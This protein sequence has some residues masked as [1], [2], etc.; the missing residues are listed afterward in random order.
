[1]AS[2]SLPIEP[3]QQQ[4]LNPSHAKFSIADLMATNNDPRGA[5]RT[6][7]TTTADQSSDARSPP[8][9]SSS[10][11]AATASKPPIAPA[12]DGVDSTSPTTNLKQP[13][14][15]R[16]LRRKT[17]HSV[18]ERRRREKINERLIR[19]QEMVPAC[20]DEVMEMLDKKPLKRNGAG[21]SGKANLLTDEGER[22]AEIE[23]KCSEEMVLE[24]LCIISHTVGECFPI[25]G[26]KHCQQ[27]P[28]LTFDSLVS[29]HPRKTTSWSFVLR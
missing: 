8:S 27:A 18:I 6:S 11:A 4:H 14:K 28:E 3:A 22:K 2:S 10:R 20:R 19:L 17:D 29:A 21:G 5:A 24:K 25:L 13:R 9:R 1:M 16:V 26:T 15:S 12:E 23:R 7:N